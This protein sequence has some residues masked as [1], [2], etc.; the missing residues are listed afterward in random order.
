LNVAALKSAARAAVVIPA[1]FALADKVIQKPQVSLLA[2]FGSFALLVLTEFAGTWRMRLSAYLGL[3]C[4]GALYITV[5][6]LCSRTPWIG[7]VVMA[8]VGFATLFSGVLGGYFAA[9]GTGAI[10]TFVL[11]VTI[12]APNSVIPDRLEGWGIAVGAGTLAVMLLWP[13]RARADLARAAAGAIRTVA[14]YLDADASADGARRAVDELGRRFLG[15]QHR[16]T[17]PTGPTA[18]LSSIPDELDWLLSF[19]TPPI[20]AGC[21]ED[22]TAIAA[23]AG[24]LRASAERLDGADVRPDFDALRAARDEVAHAVVRRLPDAPD[25]DSLETPFRIRVATYSARQ[26]AAYALLASGTDVPELHDGDLAQAAAPRTAL[27]AVEQVVVEHV[28][29][30]SVWFQN[31]VRAAAGLGLAVYIAQSTGVQHGFWVVLGTLS[32]LRSNALGTGWSIVTALAGTAVGLVVGAGLVIGIGT[33]ESVLWIVLPFAI[34]LASYAPR[35]ISFAAGQAGFTVTL[36]ILFNLIQPVG[37]RVGVVRVEDVAIGFAISLG[38]GLLFWPR[39]AAALLRE[40]LADAFARGIDYVVIATR[41][42]IEGGQDVRSAAR[43]ADAAIHRVDDAFR[44]YLAERVATEFDVED[45]AAGVNAA[46]RIHRSAQSMLSLGRMVSADG[47]LERCGRNLDRELHAVQSWY[48]SL[49]YSLVNVRPV[50]PPHLR[51]VEGRELLLECIRESARSGDHA[52]IKAAIGLLWTAQHLD[53][54][55]RLES[56]IAENVRTARRETAETGILGRLKVLA[57]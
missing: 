8:V 41:E 44:Q 24:A 40:Q 14:D 29:I 5:G 10:L 56:R 46:M 49:G 25:F 50:P 35:A 33:H 26:V 45:V 51:D 11:P 3:G 7:A 37:W 23:A 9:A 6:T 43:S 12:P 36:F 38:V 34:L 42:L 54:L 2:A 21:G 19:V 53:S 39:G 47:R 22:R 55:W 16:P 48:L 17:G 31:S 57:T 18:A 13:P 15:S 1:V 4:V 52:S 28:S 20:E 32:V 27:D 30:G